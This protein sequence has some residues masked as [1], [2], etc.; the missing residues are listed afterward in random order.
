MVKKNFYTNL[1]CYFLCLLL[2]FF[3]GCERKKTK[4][5][6][7]K[8]IPEE[9]VDVED[10]RTRQRQKEFSLLLEELKGKNPFS[11]TPSDVDKY[12]FATGGLSLSGIFYDEK[13]PL[14]IINEQVVAEGD[15][16][17]DK[18]IIKISQNEVILRDKEKEYRLKTE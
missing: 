13:R 2:L 16:L 18:R 10:L 7:E 12:R 8:R 5:E 6:I 3:L 4:P 14:A 15:M 1:I 11:K 17:G 9:T